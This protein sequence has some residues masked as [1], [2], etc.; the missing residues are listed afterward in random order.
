MGA[1]MQLEYDNSEVRFKY[2]PIEGAPNV[3]AEPRYLVMDGQQRLTSMYRSLYGKDAVATTNGKHA[4]ISRFYYLG[5]NACLDSSADRY[6]AAI[7]V[8]EDRKIKKNFDRDVKLDLSTRELEYENE[9][10]PANILFDSSEGTK[11]LMGYMV[12]HQ[13]DPDAMAKFTRFQSEI[14]ETVT[15]YRLP[16]IT[17]DKNTPREAVCKVFENVN[18][19]GVSLTVFELVTATF[20]TY[21]FDLRG[22][23][24]SRTSAV[25]THWTR[26]FARTSPR[27][28]TKP[29]T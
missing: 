25:S 20:A 12:H 14:I 26:I 11:W 6:D 3:D 28:S 17:M 8:P 16:V 5:M 1:L 2:R 24:G 9:M 10:Y 15:S 7:S 19:G 13:S 4:P 18:T 29:R 22:D 27:A 21:E 23:W